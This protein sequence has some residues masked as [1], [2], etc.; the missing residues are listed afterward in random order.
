[1]FILLIEHLYFRQHES[2]TVPSFSH[3]GSRGKKRLEFS[4]QK[5]MEGIHKSEKIKSEKLNVSSF[6]RHIKASSCSAD[7]TLLISSEYHVGPQSCHNGA[8]VV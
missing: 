3:I 6:V 1:M 4:R 5:N 7:T 2:H 8:I